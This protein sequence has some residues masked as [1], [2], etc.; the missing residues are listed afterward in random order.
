MGEPLLLTASHWTKAIR[1]GPVVHLPQCIYIPQF[2]V[3]QQSGFNVHN[4][5]C[6]ALKGDVMYWRPNTATKISFMYSQK[7]N[8][9]A[10]VPI[11]T[12][13]CLW[14]IYICPGSVHYFTYFL[15]QNR[16]FHRGN[17]QS[18]TDT[19]M[20]KLGLWLRNYFSGNICFEYSVF[21]FCRA[22]QTIL[23]FHSFN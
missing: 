14:A 2:I 3:P 18:F 13:M 11:S 9:A 4:F 23:Q 22:L 6:F 5:K 10:S 12:F 19:W 7:R 8:C 16:Q 21:V 1:E 17:I 15:Q 20:W